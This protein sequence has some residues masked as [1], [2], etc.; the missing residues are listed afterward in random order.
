MNG[1]Q[2]PARQGEGL[3][4]PQAPQSSG[5]EFYQPNGSLASYNANKSGQRQSELEQASQQGMAAGAK[6]GYAQANQELAQAAVNN[7]AASMMNQQMGAQQQVEG[8]AQAILSGQVSQEQISQA[9][10]SGQLDPSM[11]DAAFTMASQ[12]Q[13]RSQGL[14]GQF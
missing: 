10:R 14:G 13:A 4:Q 6:Q 7:Q 8:M 9:V 2:H 3:G 1:L 5:A 11:A 12:I